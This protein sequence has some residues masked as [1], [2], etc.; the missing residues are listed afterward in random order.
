MI[1]WFTYRENK[2]KPN[3]T[4]K[5]RKAR[6]ENGSLLSTRGLV[7]IKADDQIITKI[8]GKILTILNFK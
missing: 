5:N 4:I 1:R 7:V 3:V 6:A 8:K 2:K